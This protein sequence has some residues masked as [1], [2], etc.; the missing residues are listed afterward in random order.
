LPDPKPQQRCPLEGT[1]QR[2]TVVYTALAAKIHK[3]WSLI[4][5]L[6]KAIDVILNPILEVE[7]RVDTAQDNVLPEIA[8]VAPQ[9]I[10]RIID[11]P[12]VMQKADPTA[13][14]NLI[15]NK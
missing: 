15:N 13:K 2:V 10:T 3:G 14:H 12:A 5:K 11:A 1:Y 9:T 6:Q 7:Q 4:Q 8:N